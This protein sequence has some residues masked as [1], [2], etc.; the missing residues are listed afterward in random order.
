MSVVSHG[1]GRL[2]RQFLEDLAHLPSAL[3]IQV[4]VTEN[5]AETEDWLPEGHQRSRYKVI[6][7][8]TPQGF[9]ANHNQAFRQASG[10]Y[11]CIANPDIRLE[12]DP[13]PAL[14]RAASRVGAA[15]VTPAVVNPDGSVEDHVRRFPTLLNLLRRRLGGDDG[16]YRVM[17][18]SP[19]AKVDWAAGMFLLSPS[20]FFAQLGGF[21]ERFFMYC[22]DVDLSVRAWQSGGQV[23]VEPS[24]IVV[25]EAARATGR[26]F[27]PTVWHL[28]SMV[29]YFNKYGLAPPV[30]PAA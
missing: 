24:A 4:I 11:F 23:W 10:E 29:A 2:I 17:P 5:I 21:D 1:H 30:D 20:W 28:R 12:G 15:I 16:A 14:V 3:R 25:H 18:G 9:G 6:E 19:A 8:D 7:N 26:A 22:E 13:F 27:R